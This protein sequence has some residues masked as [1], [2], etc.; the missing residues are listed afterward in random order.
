MGYN[1]IKIHNRDSDNYFHL[2]ASVSPVKVNYFTSRIAI[3][4]TVC[5]CSQIKVSG[6][7]IPT[8]KKLK[9]V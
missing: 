3:R 7:D 8:A 9:I 1:R 4:F 2:N 5:S 6:I